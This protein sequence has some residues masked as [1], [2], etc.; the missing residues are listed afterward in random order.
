MDRLDL[1]RWPFPTHQAYRLCLNQGKV[2]LY[3]Q[4]ARLPD[5]YR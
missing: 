4:E 5:E 2:A 3:T 1:I